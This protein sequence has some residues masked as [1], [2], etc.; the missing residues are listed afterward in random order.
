LQRA[1]D[2]H[3]VGVEIEADDVA[4]IDAMDLRLR[5][6]PRVAPPSPDRVRLEFRSG[7]RDSWPTAKPLLPGRPVYDTPHGSLYYLEESDTI[8]GELD[9]VQLRCE[10][11]RGVARLRSAAFSG[12]ALYLATHPLATIGLME[13]MERR[14]LFSL[15]A[16]CLADGDGRGVL[17]AGASGA[18]KSTLALAL[19][20]EGMEFLSDDLVFIAPDPVRVLGFADALG[21]TS[22]S[23]QHFADLQPMLDGPPSVGFRKRLVRGEEVFGG[24]ARLSCEP[25]VLVFPFVAADERSRIEPLDPSDALLR[26]VP[27]VLLTEPTSSQAHLK[28]IAALLAQVDCYALRSGADLHCA[29]RL[30]HDLLR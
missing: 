3:G 18:G 8:W 17:L 27:D 13:V 19:A 15:H 29:T 5:G 30:V 1:Y 22:A 23:A 28:A 4:V 16:A 11:G 20:F 24:T 2:V 14:G 25:A 10:P 6:F 7:E 12:R 21:L 26:L 9:D